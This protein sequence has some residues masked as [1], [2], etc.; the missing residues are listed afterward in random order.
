MWI[1][2]GFGPDEQPLMFRIALRSIRTV[3]RSKQA[4]IVLDATLVS[5][6]HCR[7]EARRDGVDV[8]DL[9]STNGTFV[10]NRRI[11]RAML[12]VGDRLRIGR[13]EFV[14]ERADDIV[15]ATARPQPA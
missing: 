5:R 15:D 7:L 2:R 13:V 6:L 11:E 12:D 9:A 4:D 1:L 10:N 3:G 8:I 14:I